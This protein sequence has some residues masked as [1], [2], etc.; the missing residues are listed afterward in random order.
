MKWLRDKDKFGVYLRRCVIN[1]PIGIYIF[2]I[3]D[4]DCF[5]FHKNNEY[6][7]MDVYHDGNL[8]KIYE[9]KGDFDRIMEKSTKLVKKFFKSEEVY[10]TKQLKKIRK[11][12]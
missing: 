3:R 1:T 8:L 5:S 2:E 6:Y 4:Q 10:F 12:L 7:Y 9:M 11:S